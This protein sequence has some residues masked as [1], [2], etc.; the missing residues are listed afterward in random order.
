MYIL[1]YIAYAVFLATVLAVGA[2]FFY[3]NVLNNQLDALI[4][5]LDA[6]RVSFSTGDIVRI[7]EAERR[8]KLA[9]YLFNNHASTYAI[10]NEIERFAVDGVVFTS[11]SYRRVDDDIARINVAGGSERFDSTAFQSSILSTGDV[12]ATADFVGISK[13]G[14]V[15]QLEVV[16]NNND[17]E[18]NNTEILTPVQFAIEQD[19]L[20]SQIPFSQGNYEVR[21]PPPAPVTNPSETEE[22]TGDTSATDTDTD[23][24]ANEP[25]DI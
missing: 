5:E 24:P 22:S 11:F 16:Q 25:S 17:N 13:V 12:F 2:V 14:D 8:H 21:L 1:S 7:K 6:Q 20:V 9:E 15:S 18:N 23:V 4:T 10:F 3:A 19:L